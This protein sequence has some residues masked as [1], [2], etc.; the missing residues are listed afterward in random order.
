MP[1]KMKLAWC[2]WDRSLELSGSSEI[3]VQGEAEIDVVWVREGDAMR[4]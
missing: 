2:Q 1:K 3:D 4:C